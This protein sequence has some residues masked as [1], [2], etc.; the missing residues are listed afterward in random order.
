MFYSQL[1]YGR[2]KMKSHEQKYRDKTRE[3]K[4]RKIKDDKKTKSKKAKRQ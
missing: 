2:L 3:K 4:R 1:G